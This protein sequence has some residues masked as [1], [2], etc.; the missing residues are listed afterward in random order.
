[1]PVAPWTQE[2][3][4]LTEGATILKPEDLVGSVS[5]EVHNLGQVT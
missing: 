4:C 2:V 1:M 5:Y 3:A